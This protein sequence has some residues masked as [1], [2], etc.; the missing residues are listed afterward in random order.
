[1]H[2]SLPVTRRQAI[3]SGLGAVGFMVAGRWFSSYA[4]AAA[5]AAAPAAA[6]ADKSAQAPTSPVAIQRCESY[7]PKVVREQLA[8]ALKLIGGL[9]DMVRGKTVTVKLN[10]VG[11]L[12]PACGLPAI[13]TYHTNPNV[14]AA[15]CAILADAGAKQIILAEGF[16]FVD[17]VE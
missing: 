4:E 17:P 1:M 10:L 3:I 7:D 8:A 15:M 9:G 14:V 13:R 5:A 6:P 11:G 2:M 12:S 16:F